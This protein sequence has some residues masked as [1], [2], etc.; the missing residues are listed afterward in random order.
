M[1]VALPG[2]AA[3]S[4]GGCWDGWRSRRRARLPCGAPR[5]RHPPDAAVALYRKVGY[6]D[7][8]RYNDNPKAAFWFERDLSGSRGRPAPVE[9]AG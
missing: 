1:Y 6:R 8:P 4:A 2:A 3:G 9:G 7:I 5:Q